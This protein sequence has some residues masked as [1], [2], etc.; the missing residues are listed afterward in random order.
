MSLKV[1]NLYGQMNVGETKDIQVTLENTGYSTI[2]YPT[3][4]IDPS[5]NTIV[6]E[7]SPIDV[8]AILPGQSQV[9][10]LHVTAQEGTAQGDYIINVKGYSPEFLT[11][12]VDIRMTVAASSSQ[13]LI[14]VAVLVVAFMSI[15]LVYRRFRR[16]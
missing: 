5:V 12:P 2:T 1:A 11:D 8:I 3:L 10:T 16:R 9:F 14:I 13:T 15:I 7:Y 6:V 4:L